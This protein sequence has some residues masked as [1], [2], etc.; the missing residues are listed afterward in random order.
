[1]TGQQLLT[2]TTPATPPPAPPTLGPVELARWAW[3]QLTSMRTALVLLFCLALAAVPGSLVPQQRV[4]PLAVRAFALEHPSLAPVFD[5]IGLFDVYSSP[6]FSA[7]YLLLMVSLIGCVVPRSRVYWRALRAR[8]PRAPRHL[9]RLPVHRSWLADAPP[10]QVAAAAARVLVARR[11]RVERYPEED[12]SVV[13]AA[14]RGHLR[15][16]GN[17][18]FHVALIVVLVGVALGS[19]YGFKGG[20]IVTE[21]QSFANTL[22]QYD[23][24]SPGG[25]FDP[26]DLP[27][28]SLTVRSFDATF[29]EDGPQRGAPLAFSAQVAYTSE[30]GAEPLRYDLRVNHPLQVDG[31]SVFLIGH[32]YAPDIAVR[33]G[34]GRVV[35]AGP[36]TFL[37]QDGS[38]TSYG[39]VKVPDAAPRQLG[40]EGFFLPTFDFDPTAGPM[41]TFP[42]ARNPALVLLAYAGDLGL[43]DGLP[44]SV[45]ELDRAGLT[46]LRSSDGEPFRMLLQ[47]GDTRQLPDGAGSITFR[48]LDR[49]VKLQVSQ[50]PGK[51]VPLVGVLVA[52]LGLLGTLFVRPRRSWLRARRQAG[53]T[54]VEAA[55]LDRTAGG[56]LAGE[57]DAL[58]DRLRRD[59]TE[60][61][62]Q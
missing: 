53:R 37:P 52:I 11:Y 16:A 58:V 45:Y 17:L 9:S 57:L 12:G 29:Q 26:A 38:L 13:V 30:P 39:V 49:W 44:Q 28:F 55:G 54:V 35:F 59:V 51:V 20:V 3:R 23:E 14:E 18:V 56:D 36:V 50:T 5:R 48:G 41:S 60:E 47:P 42:D 31:T 25:R 33:D 6:W 1:M 15:E 34:P 7:I 32:G 10:E 24:F 8:P 40:F 2:D 21:G 4:D 61:G 27:P 62:A 22:T 43:D 46:R 19:L